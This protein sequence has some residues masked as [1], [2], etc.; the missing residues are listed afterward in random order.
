MDL[1]KPVGSKPYNTILKTLAA[2]SVIEA[3]IVMKNA[4][5]KLL[6]KILQDYPEDIDIDENGKMIAKTAVTVDDTWQRRGYCSKIGVVF[7]LAVST[8][9]VLDREVKSLICHEC[10]SHKDDEKESGK[11]ISWYETHKATCHINHTGSSDAMET[12]GVKEIFLRSV[13]KRKLKYTTFVGD[14]DRGSFAAVKEACYLKYGKKY[15]VSKEECVGHVQKRIGPGLREYKKRMRGK[16]S[17]D[18]KTVGG[19]KRLTDKVLDNIQ[20]Y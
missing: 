6:N 7:V 4:G 20:N 18:G 1:P 10:V 9:E 8:G 3:E 15:V 17:S 11:Y 14:G 16:K 5:G 19:A 12:E 2:K 13:E